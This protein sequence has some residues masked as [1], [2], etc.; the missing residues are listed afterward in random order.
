MPVR[1][2]AAAAV[3]DKTERNKTAKGAARR[4]R[5][6]R[7]TA[8]NADKHELYQRS[9]QDPPTE[10]AFVDR[11]YRR[12]FG[13]RPLTLREDFCGTALFCADW[14]K[15]HRQ[16]QAVGVDL[17][18]ATLAWGTEHNLEPLGE[19]GERV[20]LLQQDVRAA[21]PPSLSGTIDVALALNFSYWVFKSRKELVAYFGAVRE[22]LGKE[23]LFVLDVY[24][25]PLSMQS[26]EEEDLERTRVKGGFTYVWHQAKFDAID[27]SILNHIHFEF[28]DGTALRKAFTYDWRFWTIPEIAECLSEAGYGASRVYWEDE[29]EEGE[30]T[31]V[32]R[33]RKRAESQ[34]AWVAYII[35]TP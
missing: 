29:D 14:I 7:Y 2:Y 10:I 13:R 23:A 33:A 32:Y 8:S 17:D 18:A 15:S 21:L 27:H 24:G 34:G 1:G 6:S 9:V 35:A 11:V 16:R 3:R 5:G 31:G 19:P 4:L 22:S 20:T 25:G 30:G 28:K 12:S 26:M